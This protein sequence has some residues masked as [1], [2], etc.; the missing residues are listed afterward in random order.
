MHREIEV[1][2]RDGFRRG[3]MPTTVEMVFDQGAFPAADMARVFHP[4]GQELPVQVDI[5]EQW[6]GGSI[7]RAAVTFA[8]RIDANG[9]GIYRFEYGE[10]VTSGVEAPNPVEIRLEGEPVEV[11]QGPVI[12]RV[13]RR[14]FNLVDEV[15]FDRSRWKGRHPS[16]KTFLGA[17]EFLS[18]GSRGMLLRLKDGRE[19]VVEGEVEI[20][21]ETHGPRSGRLRV[22][23]AYPDGYRFVT[24]LTFY[25]GVSWFR[26]EHEVVEGDVSEI[27][28]FVAE[29]DCNLGA[30]PIMS[31]FGAR[32]G[33][34]GQAA[35]WAVLTDDESTVDAA[36]P[37]AWSEAGSVRHEVRA[38]G[39]FRMIFP[40]EGKPR[41]LYYHFLITPPMDHY[42]TPAAAMVTDLACRVL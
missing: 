18:S 21:A 12:Y 1:A 28:S 37:D 36:V 32:Q 30:A 3:G 16:G 23:G 31:A 26:V 6:E 9:Q 39:Q 27:A 22:E 10:G 33:A 20:E 38:D 34:D 15:S 13:R 24:R 40:F 25:S 19:L 41:V 7:R 35:S 4:E 5:L 42:H 2:E 29:V 11:Q 8:A 14:G 17:K